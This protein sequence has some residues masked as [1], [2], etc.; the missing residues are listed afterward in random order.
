MRVTPKIL[1]IR[2]LAFCGP[3]IAAL[4]VL[5]PAHAAA[6]C[7]DMAFDS[8]SYT[9]CDVDLTDDLRLFHSGP[10]GVLGNFSSVDESLAPTD[11][12]LGF[13]MNAGMYHP[14]RAPVGLYV[15]NGKAQSRLITSDG[16][17]NFGLLPNG[18][19]CIGNSFAIIESRTF[20]KTKPACTFATQSGPMLV[21]DGA[22]RCRNSFVTASALVP[23]AAMRCSPS[24]TI[25]STSTPSPG[26]F[27]MR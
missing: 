5:A 9:L 14:D 8:A 11:Q 24:P 13:A 21:I 22:D 18:V 20:A 2:S 17:G 4:S 15:Q 25:R 23:M 16:P 10:D 26:C 3:L 12:R 1:A 19:F 6:A 27:A 7:H